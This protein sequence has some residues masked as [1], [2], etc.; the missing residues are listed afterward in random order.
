MEN[1]LS[2]NLIAATTFNIIDGVFIGII[3]LVAIIGLCTGFMKNGLN[4]VATIGTIV[5]TVILTPILA[6][7]LLGITAI[8]SLQESFVNMLASIGNEQTALS[9][10]AVI[11]YVV[12]ALV[13]LLVIGLVFKLIKALL[14]KLIK[15]KRGVLKII[16]R[17]LGM[18]F[19]VA[20]YGCICFGLLGVIDTVD[21]PEVNTMMEQSFIEQHNFLKPFCEKN[22]NIGKL[23]EN[24]DNNNDQGDNEQGGEQDISGDEPTA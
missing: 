10:F 16:D 1:G 3:V 20:L 2:N 7:T 21:K 19:G 23:F 9:I 5:G 22:L 24:N 8:A 14:R 4:N 6:K 17:L 11:L 18:V 12:V 15:P 13:L